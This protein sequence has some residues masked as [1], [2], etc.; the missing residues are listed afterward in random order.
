MNEAIGILRVV[1]FFLLSYLLHSCYSLSVWK[2]LSNNLY[3][4]IYMKNSVLIRNLDKCKYSKEMP[5]FEII[6][7]LYYFST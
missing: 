7:M 5:S 6:Y 3:P 1:D 2:F 4:Y